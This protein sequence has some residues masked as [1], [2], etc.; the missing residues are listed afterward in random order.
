MNLSEVA[1]AAAITVSVG[2]VSYAALNVDGISG[3]TRAVADQASC[4]TVDAAVVA[5]V[6]QHGTAPTT[7]KQLAPYVKGDIS[8]YRIVGGRA[9]GP[10]CQ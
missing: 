5:F 7:I 8:A 1:M 4:H 2:G 10:G 9:A 6:A 3:S